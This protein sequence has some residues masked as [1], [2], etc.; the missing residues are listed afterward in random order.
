M[1]HNLCQVGGGLIIGL[2][3]HFPGQIHVVCGRSEGLP[4]YLCTLRNR[5]TI[6]R[7]TICQVGGLIVGL[8]THF[9]GQISSLLLTVSLLMVLLGMHVTLG[10]TQVEL[11]VLFYVVT[12]WCGSPV[13]ASICLINTTL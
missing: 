4:V 10:P 12:V 2:A 8:A 6:V 1:K 3:T 9:S 13:L 11:K 5:T 7:N